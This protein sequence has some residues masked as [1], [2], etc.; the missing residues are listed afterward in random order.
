M[1]CAII[2][3]V[4]RCSKVRYSLI[5]IAILGSL[6][7]ALALRY[8]VMV[9]THATELHKIMNY[10]PDGVIVCNTEGEVVYVNDAVRS[11]TGFTEHDLKIGGVLQLIPEPL[12][13]SHKSGMEH[14][15]LK[16]SRGIE[17]VNYKHIYPVRKKDGG[18]IICIVSVG[19]LNRAGGPQF[20]A[21]ISPVLDRAIE[22]PTKASPESS[23]SSY[24]AKTAE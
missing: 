14:A 8:A 22:S 5:A 6:L 11:L 21:F 18:I 1:T 9:T 10:A 13:A 19:S 23:P 3:A 7:C 15:R 20:F 17:G 12:Q 24:T 16:S 2:A 4:E